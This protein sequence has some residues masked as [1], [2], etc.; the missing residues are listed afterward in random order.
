MK[1]TILYSGVVYLIHRDIITTGVIT[2]YNQDRIYAIEVTNLNDT[3]TVVYRHHAF[4]HPELDMFLRKLKSTV[5]YAETTNQPI[6][7]GFTKPRALIRRGKR[8]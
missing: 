8:D 7:K 1:S 2:N 5:R 6:E 3:K 4:I